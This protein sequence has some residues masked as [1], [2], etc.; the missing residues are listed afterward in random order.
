MTDE[1]ETGQ[2]PEHKPDENLRHK[3]RNDLFALLKAGAINRTPADESTKPPNSPTLPPVED[4]VLI[5]NDDGSQIQ[6]D[7]CGRIIGTRDINGEERRFGWT[8]DGLLVEVVLPYARWTSP[9]GMLWTN[10]HGESRRGLRRVDNDGTYWE[11]DEQ[12]RKI[13][14]LDGTELEYY[15][16]GGNL[17]VLFKNGSVLSERRDQGIIRQIRNQDGS[18]FHYRLLDGGVLQPLYH[19]YAQPTRIEF[20]TN[21]GVKLVEDVSEVTFDWQSYQPNAQITYRTT[22]GTTYVLVRGPQG[23]FVSLSEYS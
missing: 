10:S 5:R 14:R 21:Q 22:S 18:Q 13:I 4:A 1:Q 6:K 3:T 19:K 2:S 15:K 7:S 9:D 8:N 16:Q 11:E 17:S 12:R 23:E 20:A